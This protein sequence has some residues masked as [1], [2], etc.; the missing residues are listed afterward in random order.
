MFS[1]CEA[2]NGVGKCEKYGLI[3][4]PKCRT[5]YTNDGCCICKRI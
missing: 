5:G 1:R 4:Y 2:D 3:V